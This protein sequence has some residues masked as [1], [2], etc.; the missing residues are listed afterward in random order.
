MA[1]EVEE[2]LATP[3]RAAQR[4]GVGYPA[5]EP[6]REHG[7]WRAVARTQPFE[8]DAVRRVDELGSG[9]RQRGTTGLRP[10]RHGRAE[11]VRTAIRRWRPPEVHH[12]VVTTG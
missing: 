7:H 2:D 5:T 10:S 3:Y 1:A 11:P 12:G 4:P 9:L 6:V 8:L